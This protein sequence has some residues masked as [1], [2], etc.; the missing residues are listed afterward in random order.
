MHLLSTAILAEGSII[1]LDGTFLVQLGIFF[2]AFLLLTPLVF[3]PM[4]KLFEAREE[5]ID[6]ALA[7]ARELR[8]GVDEAGA[9]FEDKMRE[10]RLQAGQERERL[11]AQGI[12]LE[13]E[14]LDKVRA[15]TD[16]QLKEA[17]KQLAA[18]AARV[19]KDMEVKVPALA[20]QIATKL[21]ERQV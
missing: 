9:E 5:A 14:L 16:A 21:L 2:I 4:V 6:N 19:R 3:K 7:R 20:R 15:E 12:Q 13:R 10:V 11:R 1:D 17:D 18:E 8:H